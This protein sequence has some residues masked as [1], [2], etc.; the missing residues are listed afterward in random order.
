MTP[1]VPPATAAPAADTPGV[2][3]ASIIPG[4]NDTLRLG[5]EA[6]VAVTL[7]ET[8]RA[9]QSRRLAQPLPPAG[10]REH[11][12]S[13]RNRE[14]SDV[15]CAEADT[16]ARAACDRYRAAVTR[17]ASTLPAS[18]QHILPAIDRAVWEKAT[19]WPPA[20]EGSI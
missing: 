5:H 14:T 2:L 19:L 8:M 17:L 12:W 20:Q 18:R 13:V 6:Y 9:E 15:R 7:A 3:V 4:V 1:A 10:T 11:T 16:R